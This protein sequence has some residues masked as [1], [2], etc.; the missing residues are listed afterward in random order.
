MDATLTETFKKNA[1]YRFEAG[2]GYHPLN[3]YWHERGVLLHS[4]FRVDGDV[5]AG[6]EQLR[7]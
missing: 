3:T 7:V 4:E 1:L 6:H 5:T 2:K